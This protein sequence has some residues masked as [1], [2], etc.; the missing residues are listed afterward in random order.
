MK[1]LETSNPLLETALFY[2]KN[3]WKIFPIYNPIEGTCS[4]QKSECS[5]PGKHPRTKR[6]FKNA[7]SDLQQ[8]SD[9]WKKWPHANIGIS[10]GLASGLIVI[11]VDFRHDGETSLNSLQT[12]FPATFD[13]PNV[14]TGNGYHFYFAYPETKSPISS[15]TQFNGLSGIDIRGEGG[16]IIAP[17]SQHI[18]GKSYQ[19]KN[20][21]VLLPHKLPLFPQKLINT[22]LEHRLYLRTNPNLNDCEIIPE[23]KRN[24]TLT[25]IAGTMRNRGLRDN[26][27]LPALYEI[28]KYRCIPPLPKKEVGNIARSV[29]RY[30]SKN[31]VFSQSEWADPIPLRTQLLPVPKFDLKLLPNF[32]GQWVNNIAH[33]IQCPIEYVAV[34]AIIALTTVIGRKIGIK[35]KV[36]DPWIVT[37]NLWGCIVG[38]P[39]QMKS[40][41]VKEAF[42]PLKK[43]AKNENKKF[44]KAYAEYENQTII[45][46]V[47]IKNL[48]IPISAAQKKKGGLSNLELKKKI[49]KQR[50]VLKENKP[51]L[52]RYIV[53]DTTS[54]KLGEILAENS[55]GVLLHRDE[56]SG[57]LASL[58]KKGNEAD[59]SLYLESWNGDGDFSYDRIERGTIIIDHLCLSIFGTIQPDKLLG[60]LQENI[61][62][63]KNDGL[64]Q[65]FQLFVY[66]DPL[67]NRSYI[68]ESIDEELYTKITQIFQVL[69]QEAPQFFGAELCSETKTSYLRFDHE[70]QSLFVKWFYKHLHKC[71]ELE[72]FPSL[73]EHLIKYQKL[74][75]A[76]AL[77]LHLASIAAGETKAGSVSAISSQMAIKWT[78]FLESHAR[79]IYGLL[80]NEKSDTATLLLAKIKLGDVPSKFSLRNIYNKGWRGLADGKKIKKACSF[81]EEYGYLRSHTKQPTSNGGRKSITYEVNPKFLKSQN[82]SQKS[83]LSNEGFAGFE[84]ESKGVVCA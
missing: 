46:E 6:G 32:L 44:K 45:N 35:P 63:L 37:P 65:R 31:S 61:Q 43:L 70:A 71:D 17:P 21:E 53:N 39:G 9:W 66:P 27:I 74:M 68:D 29:S 67:K 82:K 3:G 19:W 38:S 47:N 55:Q 50:K 36:N 64:I 77:I 78:E 69:D 20:D 57:W 24:T 2:A 75:P 11:D 22:F 42:A 40:P 10:T 25:S 7:T 81:L 73:Q 58:D 16:Y 79:R 12:K 52:K 54:A 60:Y 33:R 48:N 80:D 15:T 49:A 76:L 51:K 28:N 26:E 4:C 13:S 83:D 56:I 14:L 84:G 18:S 23:G 34:T 72:N 8:I 59:R 41:A 5:S 1:N 62:T 30:E